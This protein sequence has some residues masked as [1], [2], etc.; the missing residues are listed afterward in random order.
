M[1]VALIGDVHA[2]LPAL[3]AVLTHARQRHVEAIWNVGDY[4]GYGA[5]PD[6][7]VEL[8]KKESTLNIIGNYDLKMLRIGQE[9][10]KKR[11]KTRKRLAFRWTYEALSKRNRKYLRGLSRELRLEVA[12]K[13]VLLTHGSP[14]SDEEHLTP[15]TPQARLREVWFINTGSVG[16]PDDGDPRACYA[17]LQVRPGYFRVDHY[18][19]PYDVERAAAAIRAQ[20]LPEEFAQ[21]ILQ[22][23]NLEAIQQAGAAQPPSPPEGES[24]EEETV[25]QALDWQPQPAPPP[26]VSSE[27]QA[28]L[29]AVLQLAWDTFYEEEHTQQVTRLALR[30]FDELQPLH[31]LDPKA[32]FWLRCGALLHDIGWVEGW[33]AHHKTS[34]RIILDTPALPLAK[35]ERLIVGSIARYHRR[36]HP[37]PKHAHFAALEP[38]DQSMVTT[39]AAILRVADALDCTHQSIVADLTAEV[40]TE[41]IAIHCTV[42]RPAEAERQDA[43]KKGL[44]LAERFARKLTIAWHLL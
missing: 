12:G 26:A 19:V 5:F 44:L 23:R 31:G 17:I 20:H 8:L 34:L 10:Q 39:L 6:E 40:S 9:P 2:N 15:E 27:Q 42:H 29:Q 24:V 14:A 13:R 35:R 28:Q 7:V 11:K 36:A 30:L 32:R 18:R 16:R 41:E 25:P 33:R 22:G 43:L 1:K 38:R 21:M 3:E 4:V 37:R